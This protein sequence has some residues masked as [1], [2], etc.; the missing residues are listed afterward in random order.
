MFPRGLYTPEPSFNALFRLLDDFDSYSRDVSN[1]NTGNGHHHHRRHVRTFNPRFDVVET[2]AAYELHGDLAGVEKDN[3]QLEFT[4]P[5]TLVV[6]GR[7]ER[8]YEAGT[9]PTAAQPA[10]IE[11]VQMSGALPEKEGEWQDVESHTKEH[12]ASVEDEKDETET[13]ATAE[14]PAPATP[15]TTSTEVAKPAEKAAAA[16]PTAP[17][18]SLKYWVSE[19]SVGEFSRTF[20]FPSRIEQDHVTANLNNGVLTVTVPKA[21]KYESRRVTVN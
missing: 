19:R 3:V 12:Q 18:N 9:P 14:A 2:E 7:V 20:S 1:N 5:Q 11:D 10:A 21:K 17:K 15:A 4:D 16:A 8:R 13:T 6:R